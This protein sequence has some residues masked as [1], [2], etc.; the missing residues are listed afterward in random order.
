M[1]LTPRPLPLAGLFLNLRFG[2]CGR[3][4]AASVAENASADARTITKIL[5]RFSIFAAPSL[6]FIATLHRSH[7]GRYYLPQPWRAFSNC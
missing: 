7:V 3:A 1:I 4:P 2:C 5:E 6:F